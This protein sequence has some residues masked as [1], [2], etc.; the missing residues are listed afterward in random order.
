MAAGALLLL[1]AAGGPAAPGGG[2]DAPRSGAGPEVVAV[3][4]PRPLQVVADRGMLVVL[5]PGARGDVAGEIY[6]F[7]PAAPGAGPIDLAST[8]RLRIPFGDGRTA[9]LGSLARDP[10]G[11]ALYLGEENGRR[12][13]RL[14]GGGRL[15]LFATGLRR[16][17]GGSTL[18][19]DELGRLV[20]LDWVDPALSPD[21]ERGLPGLEPFREE[22]YRGPLILRVSTDPAL[23][24]PRQLQRLAPFFPRGWGGRA[25]GASLPHLVAAAPLGGE[26]LAVLSSAGDLYRVGAD[27]RLQPLA[28]LPRGQYLRVNMAA[29]PDGSLYVSGGFWVARLFHVAPDGVVTTLADGLADPQ[30]LVLDGRGGLYLAESALHRIVRFRAR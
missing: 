5:S 11:G 21:D 13:W 20:V 9:T 10:A 24:L 28:T 2:A 6:R 30:G 22:D 3:G 25:G 29:A 27:S 8:P 7:E 1:L 17:A 23:P 26:A 18:S 4:V 14:D 19:V 12:I 15:T 16:L